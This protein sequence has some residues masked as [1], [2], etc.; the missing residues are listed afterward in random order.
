MCSRFPGIWWSVLAI[1]L[2]MGA[3]STTRLRVQTPNDDVPDAGYLRARIEQ[4]YAAEQRNDWNMFYSLAS[5]EFKTKE[6]SDEF[7]KEIK[8][9]RDFTIVEWRIHSIR[10]LQNEELPPGADA[11]AK[12][13]MDVTIEHQGAAREKADDQTDYWVHLK[14]EWYWTWRG[15]P[16]D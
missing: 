2:V 3:C 6:A 9:S 5:P 11:A 12:V 10:R 13:A 8:G 4:L 16:N 15:W 1:A 14:G 7:K